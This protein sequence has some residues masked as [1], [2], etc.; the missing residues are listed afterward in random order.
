MRIKLYVTALAAIAA[1]TTETRAQYEMPPPV[2]VGV[3]IGIGAGI[4]LAGN[5]QI[6]RIPGNV[7]QGRRVFAA[8][9]VLGNWDSGR[10]QISYG[11]GP[12][13]RGDSAGGLTSSCG[14]L[15]AWNSSSYT[16]GISILNPNTNL[17][18]FTV[19][20]LTGNLVGA[21]NYSAT[22]QARRMLEVDE[23]L[24]RT[25]LS[26]PPGSPDTLN[27]GIVMIESSSALEVVAHYKY[28]QS[29]GHLETS[30]EL[31]EECFCNTKPHECPTHGITVGGTH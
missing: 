9:F 20:A 17:V 22:L 13:S 30:R 2:G 8:K 3:G 25:L 14:G 11:P 26:N 28:A 31:H 5:I 24:I 18:S 15:M 27:T 6:E 12:D 1:L 16:T 29:A 19:R 21:S 4:G 10:T 23:A 7:V